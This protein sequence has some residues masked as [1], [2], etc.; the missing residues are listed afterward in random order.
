M[1]LGVDPGPAACRDVTLSLVF[2][3]IPRLSKARMGMN[4]IL[5]SRLGAW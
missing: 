2:M 4:E 5:P 3:A 1:D